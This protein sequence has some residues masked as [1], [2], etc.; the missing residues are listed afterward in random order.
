MVANL[1]ITQ[2][3]TELEEKKRS[4]MQMLLQNDCMM[5]LILFACRKQNFEPKRKKVLILTRDNNLIKTNLAEFKHLVVLSFGIK[6]SRIVPVPVHLFS[7]LT[8]FGGE[9]HDS[10]SG[11]RLCRFQLQDINMV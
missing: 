4:D 8:Q 11:E 6:A 7:L 10:G 3:L 2:V 5:A 1:K 9:M